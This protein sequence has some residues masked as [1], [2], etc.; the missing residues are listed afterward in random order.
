MVNPKACDPGAALRRNSSAEAKVCAQ[1]QSRAEPLYGR[2]TLASSSTIAMVR[3]PGGV[4][5]LNTT[6]YRR[7]AVTPIL[8]LRANFGGLR[9]SAAPQR[10]SPL[11]FAVARYRARCSL[12]ELAEPLNGPPQLDCRL[13][14]HF[15]DQLGAMRSDR[16]L[17]SAEHVSDLL[18]GQAVDHERKRPSHSRSVSLS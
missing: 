3:L 1:T 8:S 4:S 6:H 12:K 10:F 13:R 18:I 14:S 2:L 17:G 15:V 11:C 7:P 16:A 5:R 9:R